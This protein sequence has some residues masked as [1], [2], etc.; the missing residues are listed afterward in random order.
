MSKHKRT[1]LWNSKDQKGER[2]EEERKDDTQ[3]TKNSFISVKRR[4]YTSPHRLLL[5]QDHVFYT[6]RKDCRVFNQIPFP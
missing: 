3:Q 2:G 5:Q 4:F 1:P 6:D